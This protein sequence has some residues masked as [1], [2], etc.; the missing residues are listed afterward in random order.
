MSSSRAA[1]AA[2]DLAATGDADTPVAIAPYD[3]TWPER[4]A[5]ERAR[6]AALLGPA[7][8][9]HHIG[10][11][12]VPGLAAKPIIDLM[13]HVDDLDGP[14][15]LL[16]GRGGYAYPAAYNAQLEDRRWL[17]RP[18]ASR[19]EFH[20]H[21]VARRA[22]LDRHLAFR[23]ALRADLR[24]ATGYA[25][26]KRGLAQRFAGDREAYGEAKAAF[27]RAVEARALGG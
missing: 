8:A 6:L 20:L 16:V 25:A 2:A 4:F 14:V 5:A 11:T 21:L 23:D 27:I 19:R 13:A 22:E 26:L 15:I 9:L 1:A 18:S 10:S 3:P 17:C 7:V 24:L 12:A